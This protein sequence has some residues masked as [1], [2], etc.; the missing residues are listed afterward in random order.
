MLQIIR[1]APSRDDASADCRC[2]DARYGEG[3]RTS[4]IT[5]TPRTSRRAP[6]A[7]GLLL[8]LATFLAACSLPAPS[9][10]VDA[11]AE[12]ETV[13][14]PD[15][16]GLAGDVAQ[17][18]LRDLGLRV[19]FDAIEGSVW[20]PANWVVESQQP[21]A[22]EVEPHSLV[23]LHVGRPAP[24]TWDGLTDGT[25][26]GGD[27][28]IGQV[29]RPPVAS[30]M[31]NMHWDFEFTVSG[32]PHL[33]TTDDGKTVTMTSPLAVTR[34][35][36]AWPDEQFQKKMQFIFIA[37]ERPDHARMNES[38]GT[39]TKLECEQ[40]TLQLHESTACTVSFTAAPADLADSY[41]MVNRMFDVAAWPGQH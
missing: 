29:V 10:P 41:W 35:Q 16:V 28:A 40:E 32:P 17:Q 21:A 26:Q 5:P 36:D 24:A 38:W 6:V 23:T 30:L 18:Q 1:P 4:R 2:R 25:W 13:T 11:E 33:T 15:V 7:L 34:V 14:L 27:Y 19:N 8:T 31:G 12:V 39:N 22:G 3:M 37:G 9:T 20:S